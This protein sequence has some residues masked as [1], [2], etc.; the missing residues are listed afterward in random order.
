MGVGISFI[1]LFCFKVIFLLFYFFFKI[2]FFFIDDL[3]IRKKKSDSIKRLCVKN[4]LG[5]FFVGCCR[6]VVEGMFIRGF[7]KEEGVR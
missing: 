4:F 5:G 3:W 2:W 6:R 7:M 1:G